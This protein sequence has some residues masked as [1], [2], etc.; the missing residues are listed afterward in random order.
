MMAHPDEIVDEIN[1]KVVDLKLNSVK[2]KLI[3]N[4]YQYFVEKG[5]RFA[6]GKTVEIATRFKIE[7]KDFVPQTVAIILTKGEVPSNNYTDIKFCESLDEIIEAGK[8]ILN[9][10]IIFSMDLLVDEK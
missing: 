10:L 6:I 4:I 9:E 2:D 1:K 8:T 7:G 5:Y 3:E